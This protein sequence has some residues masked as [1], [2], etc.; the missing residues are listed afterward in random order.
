MRM[1]FKAAGQSWLVSATLLREDQRHCHSPLCA[2]LVVLGSE[3]HLLLRTPAAAVSRL[4][5]QRWSFSR[6]PSCRVHSSSYRDSGK[7]VVNR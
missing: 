5:E 4:K 6:R 2:G 1:T 7:S 3:W